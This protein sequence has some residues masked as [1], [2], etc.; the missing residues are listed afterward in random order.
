MAP[1]QSLSAL[2]AHPDDPSARY[3]NRMRQAMRVL[4]GS[5]SP[6]DAFLSVSLQVQTLDADAFLRTLADNAADAG[7]ARVQFD[8]PKRPVIVQ[9]D[10]YSLEDVVTHVLG[11]ADRYR[12]SETPIRMTLKAEGIAAEVRIHNSGPQIA[13]AMLRKIFE[14]GVSDAGGDSGQHRGQGLFVARTYMAKMGGTIEA[15]NVED[16]VEFVLRL[17]AA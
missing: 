5:A 6:S 1:L 2:H 3:V 16:G 9:A 14:Y 17:A 10:E 11:N 15:V 8:S 7:I 12:R 4:Y 13:P